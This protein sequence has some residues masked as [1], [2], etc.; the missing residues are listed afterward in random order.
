M[1]LSKGVEWAVHAATLMAL[2][3]VGH[4]LSADALADY[5]EVPAAYMAKQLQALRRAGVAQSVRGKRGG[6]RLARTA[7]KITLLDIVRA[8]EG[9][10]RVFRCTEIRQNGPCA[11]PREQCVRPC[12]IAQ[13]FAKAETAW[14]DALD[15][16]T[17]ASIM[18]EAA[19]NASPDH[20]RDIAEW[21]HDRA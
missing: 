2:L 10:V 15:A 18:A 7:D 9:P 1:Q 17:L 4:G 14:R 11:V 3:P 6:Y 19:G 20:L 5:F 13:A 8:I 12:E 16:R 21:V